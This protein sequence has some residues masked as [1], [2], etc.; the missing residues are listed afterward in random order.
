MYGQGLV[1]PFQ[2]L[3]ERHST[4]GWLSPHPGPVMN[5]W[6]SFH[7]KVEALTPA[8]YWGWFPH[9][10][11]RVLSMNAFLFREHACLLIFIKRIF[12]KLLVLSYSSV[13]VS[14]R[15][16]LW[17]WEAIQRL[18]E[19]RVGPCASVDSVWSF[20]VCHQLPF[21][22]VL[23]EVAIN[24]ARKG[25]LNCDPFKNYS[26]KWSLDLYTQECS[27]CMLVPQD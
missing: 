7:L 27:W 15:S 8:L 25:G 17:D 18:E 6:L 9:L 16:T 13:W 2:R 5:A 19:V 10:K 3:G 21:S 20:Q 26:W 24:V 4:L 12:I 11:L 23:V 22:G 1:P 14:L